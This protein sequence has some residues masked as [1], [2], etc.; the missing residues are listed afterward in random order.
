MIAPSMSFGVPPAL[1]YP[2][3]T[4]RVITG[5]VNFINFQQALFHFSTS[6]PFIWSDRIS[7][8]EEVISFSFMF[9]LLTADS[10]FVD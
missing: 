1:Q 9:L 7:F 4:A 6:S 10:S 3:Y 8:D 5:H 2:L